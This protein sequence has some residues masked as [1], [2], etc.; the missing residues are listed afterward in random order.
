MER[1]VS[2]ALK[3]DLTVKARTDSDPKDIGA[4]EPPPE[5]VEV[6]YPQE[7]PLQSPFGAQAHPLSQADTVAFIGR[8]QKLSQTDEQAAT[9]SLKLSPEQAAAASLFLWKDPLVITRAP[10]RCDVLG[11]FAGM[12]PHSHLTQ[13]CSA[14][15]QH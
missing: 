3:R 4:V 10:G 14:I 12:G 8:M 13:T 6:L 9:Q 15:H 11:G 7:K 1:A 2:Q 5:S